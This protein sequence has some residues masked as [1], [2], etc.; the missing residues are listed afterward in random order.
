MTILLAFSIYIHRYLASLV[1]Q[2]FH[3]PSTGKRVYRIRRIGK[4]RAARTWVT[5][6]TAANAQR[7]LALIT[8]DQVNQ[9]EGNFSIKVQHEN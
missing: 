2:S 6:H 8:L 5:N 3:L 9:S 1:A 4:Q 7:G